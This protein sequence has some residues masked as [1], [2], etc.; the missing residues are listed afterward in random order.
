MD[1]SYFPLTRVKFTT[2][3]SDILRAEFEKKAESEDKKK[4]VSPV[5]LPTYSRCFE[6]LYN[7]R[8]LSYGQNRVKRGSGKKFE[9]Q[10]H[11]ICA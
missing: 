10:G 7:Q 2:T 5:P 11:P 9:L 3:T 8:R 4:G 1:A 6:R